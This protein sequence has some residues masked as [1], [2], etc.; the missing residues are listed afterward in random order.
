MAALP[1]SEQRERLTAL[2]VVPAGSRRSLLDRLRRGPTQPNAV[3]LI[4]ALRRLGEARELS[5]DDLDLSNIPAGR[6]KLLAR[7][8][9]TVR[10]QTIQRMPPERSIATLLAFACS[11]QAGAQ[12]DVPDVLDRLLTDLLARVDKQER[13]RRLRTIGVWTLRLCCCATLGWSCSIAPS[14]MAESG[15]KFSGAGPLSG[16]SR[17]L[18]PSV[19]SL[20]RLRIVRHLKHC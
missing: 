6:L 16:S 12:D 18:P 15:V 10:A 17:R 14:R 7:Y 9:S 19:H 8:A 1:S 20:G 4:D 2:L 11:L 3:G 5:I 13:Q